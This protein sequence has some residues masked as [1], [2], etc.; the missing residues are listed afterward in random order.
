MRIEHLLEMP[1]LVTSED[2][3]LNDPD[4][5]IRIANLILNNS[6]EVLKIYTTSK[7]YHQYGNVGGQVGL[8]SND[9]KLEYYLHYEI[10]NNDILGKCATQV[11]VWRSHYASITGIASTVVD[12]FL[13]KNFDT[14]V[15]DSYHTARGKEF[16]ITQL[17]SHISSNSVGVLRYNEISVYHPS[18]SIQQWIEDQDAW[19][20]GKSFRNIKFFISNKKL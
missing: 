18:I 8:I 15:S 3:N 1:E 4:E 2:W 9:K 6:P 19:G 17:S 12:G 13:L 16:W 20:R 5:N 7:L 10:S 14:I 11:K